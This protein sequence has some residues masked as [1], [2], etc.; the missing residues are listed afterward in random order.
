[1]ARIEGEW[2][3]RVDAGTAACSGCGMVMRIDGGEP[4]WIVGDRETRDRALDAKRRSEASPPPP[5]EEPDFS[6]RMS[7]PPRVERP[8][9]VRKPKAFARE[10]HTTHAERAGFRDSAEPE[11]LVELAWKSTRRTE[12]TQQTRIALALMV[13]VPAI[14]L[15]METR[16]DLI[17][18]FIAAVLGFAITAFRQRP[19]KLAEHSVKV[20]ADEIVVDDVVVPRVRVEGVEVRSSKEDGLHRVVLKG[21]E[22]VVDETS[23]LEHARWIEEQLSRE[24][25]AT[26]E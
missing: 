21:A 11:K 2:T 22:V 25:D 26:S 5:V 10:A 18:I 3:P 6:V 14:A 8:R 19:E 7:P 17:W 1:M 23:K 12:T 16:L 15:T 20:R 13:I 24:L 4:V 9:Q